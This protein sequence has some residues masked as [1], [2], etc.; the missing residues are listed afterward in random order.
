MFAVSITRQHTDPN[1][2]GAFTYLKIQA[3]LY[4]WVKT[5]PL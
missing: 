5:V 2:R 3:W 1:C 4:H